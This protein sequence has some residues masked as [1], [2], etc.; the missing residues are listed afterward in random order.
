MKSFWKVTKCQNTS[1]DYTH[2]DVWQKGYET[3]AGTVLFVLL[4]DIHQ[5]KCNFLVLLQT[6]GI[7]VLKS[8]EVKCRNKAHLIKEYIISVIRI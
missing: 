1:A 3:S 6:L 5:E 4:I 7:C 2:A 8:L